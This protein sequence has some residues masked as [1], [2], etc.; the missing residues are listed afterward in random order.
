[1]RSSGEYEPIWSEWRSDFHQKE[2]LMNQRHHLVLLFGWL[3]VILATIFWTRPLQAGAGEEFDALRDQCRNRRESGN[4][5]GAEEAAMQALRLAQTQLRHDP[6]F[7][8]LAQEDLGMVYEFQGRYREAAEMYRKMLAYW[9]GHK[10]ADS[11]DAATSLNFLVIALVKTGSLREAEPLA[12]RAKRIF[13]ALPKRTDLTYP[14][15]IAYNNLGSIYQRLGRN[16]EAIQAFQEGIVICDQHGDSSTRSI[17]GQLKANLATMQPSQEGPSDSPA[18]TADPIAAT[19][20]VYGPDHPQVATALVQRGARLLQQGQNEEAVRV[21]ERALDTYRKRLP[22]THPD[23]ATALWGLARAYRQMGQHSKAEVSLKEAIPI[24]EKAGLSRD[25]AQILDTLGITY[26]EQGRYDEAVATC[27]R[28]LA[29][30][31]EKVPEDTAGLAASRHNLATLYASMDEVPPEAEQLVEEAIELRKRQVD[32]DSPEMA[33]YLSTLATLRKRQGRFEDAEKLSRQVLAAREKALGPNH[34]EVASSLFNLG[35]GYYDQKRPADAVAPFEKAAAIYE[36]AGREVP[37][38]WVAY[39]YAYLARA[40]FAVGRREQSQTHL[41]KAV[42]LAEKERTLLSGTEV[43][44]AAG[45]QQYSELFETLIALQTEWGD[46]GQAFSAMERARARSLAEQMAVHGLDLLAG[47]PAVQA[48]P[49]RRRQDE[50]RSKIA[51]V[52][53]QLKA[54]TDSSRRQELEESL[55]QAREQLEAVSADIANLSPACRLAIAGAGQVAS[56]ESLRQWAGQNQALVLEYFVGRLSSFVLVVPSGGQPRLVELLVDDKQASSLSVEPGPLTSACIDKILAGGDGKGVLKRLRDGPASDGR[57][58][59]QSQLATLWTLLIPE[60]E[61][62][63]ILANQFKRLVVIPDGRLSHLPFEVLVVEDQKDPKYLLDSSAVVLYAPSVTLL[64]NLGAQPKST[65]GDVLSVGDPIYSSQALSGTDA[66]R[67]TRF[68]TNLQPLP[69]TRWETAWVAEVFGKSQV[70]TESL[71]GR[72]ATE[73][74]VRAKASDRAIL[75]FACHGL[76]DPTPGNHFGSLALTPGQDASLGDDG[77]LTLAEIYEMNLKGC[78]LAI[79]SACQTNDG[80]QQRGEGVWA[81]S[82]AFLV[83][84]SR[85]VVAS[86]WVVDDE[87]AASLVSYYC[88]GLAKALGSAKQPDYAQCLHEAKRW[89]RGQE[90]WKS[91]YYWGTFVLVGPN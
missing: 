44:R 76:V 68:A 75:H 6:G 66:A 81:L 90:K 58:P 73:K 29:I 42:E 82:R 55:R 9:E 18:A 3:F 19:E 30:R 50:A 38:G 1:L 83:A 24:A 65:A 72:E 62:T 79:L 36:Q 53:R 70:H 39:A 57:E 61:R 17:H 28:A 80:P 20:S 32:P 48:E 8:A 40:E 59:V 45:F 60:A 33:Q 54:Q 5:D 74:N 4:F 16:R 91:P 67:G 2:I 43:Q 37:F 22:P 34:P 85:R 71:T 14:W 89:V 10:G 26:G 21:F 69:F 7:A 13:D 35:R 64:L 49:L 46:C 86:N 63:A 77:F 51:E 15:A 27:K 41:H 52:Q 23:L 47:L 84:G 78:D 87:A 31:E 25:L 11:E 12:L 56:L 88:S